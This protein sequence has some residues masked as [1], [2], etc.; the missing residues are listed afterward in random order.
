MSEKDLFEEFEFKPITEGLGFHGKKKKDKAHTSSRLEP[1]LTNQALSRT[2]PEAGPTNATNTVGRSASRAA[3]AAQPLA[4]SSEVKI[5][6]SVFNTPPAPTESELQVS[7]QSVLQ[8][9]QNKR[10]HLTFKETTPSRRVVE[11]Q[12]MESYPELSAMILDTLLVMAGVLTVLISTL[13]VTKIDLIGLVKQS[14]PM[15]IMSLGYGLVTVVSLSYLFI[16]R[17]LLG[18]TPGE[19][20]T[21]QKVDLIQQKM[22]HGLTYFLRALLAVATGFVILPLVGYLSHSDLLGRLSGTRLK[23]EHLG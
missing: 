4:Q 22:S 2:P 20:T 19:W 17:Y 6:P 5:K 7:A 9:L 23:K 8:D 13:L 15:E 11:T 14:D 10:H 16:F 3:S 1:E 12:W 21:D 18:R